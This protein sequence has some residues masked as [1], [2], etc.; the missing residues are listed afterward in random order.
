MTGVR[1]HPIH[2]LFLP[3]T[4]PF[5]ANGEIAPER[6]SEQIRL[7]SAWPLAGVVLFGTS[8]EGPLLDAVE[9]APLLAAARDALPSGWKLI[10]Q[11]GRESVRATA[12]AAERAAAAGADALLCLPTRYYATD[13]DIVA[14]YYRA[15]GAATSLPILAYH[16]PSRSK[17]DLPMGLLVQLA[18]EGVLA[19]IKDS[20]GDPA[21][22]ARLRREVGP[23]F[24]ILNGKAATTADA[25]AAGADGA[26][27]AVANAAPEAALAIFEAHA[28]D[29]LET[30]GAAQRSL[31]PLA[32][33]L[34]SRYGVPGI[35]AALE[36][37]GWPGGG[38]PRAPLTPL[39]AAARSEIR[40]ALGIAL[41]D[42]GAG[43]PVPG[44]S[45]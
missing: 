45:E 5:R 32:E 2:G 40:K 29:D 25:L 38:P 15:V 12:G 14:A 37:R 33:C 8:G 17:I 27:L 41:S 42:V 1:S 34:G 28:A 22:Q 11:I 44:A 7:Y 35:K 16:I 30:A 20:A 9:E 39:G 24:V 10:A 43:L 26:I 13:A 19:G 21:L 6:L 31:L 18:G 4:T 36:E 3:V 23:G